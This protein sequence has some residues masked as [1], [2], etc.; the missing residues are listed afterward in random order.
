MTEFACLGG[1]GVL[2]GAQIRKGSNVDE[3]CFPPQN[4]NP[5]IKKWPALQT[6]SRL[7]EGTAL[8]IQ[9]PIHPFSIYESV[10]QNLI[11]CWHWFCT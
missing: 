9:I 2:L 10:F 7:R 11:S 5:Y 6:T 3:L 1:G 4:T 8:G